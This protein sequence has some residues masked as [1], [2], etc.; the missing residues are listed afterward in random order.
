M[1]IALAGPD[2]TSSKDSKGN[3]NLSLDLLSLGRGSLD[4]VV[5]FRELQVRAYGSYF[6]NK[7]FSSE[8]RKLAHWTYFDVSVPKFSTENGSLLTLER[9]SLNLIDA[10]EWGSGGRF[11]LYPVSSSSLS[12]HKSM[13]VVSELP[14]DDDDEICPLK[15]I[16][17]SN[18]YKA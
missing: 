8:K 2:K 17:A 18:Y 16:E 1:L 15:S 12:R 10:I 3:S 4:L 7:Y 9:F 11:G 14:S 13:A 5:E 6:D